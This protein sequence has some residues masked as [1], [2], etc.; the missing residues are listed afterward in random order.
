MLGPRNW[1]RWRRS[2]LGDEW[3]GDIVGARLAWSLSRLSWRL[4]GGRGLGWISAS[5]V[6]RRQKP[7]KNSSWDGLE[8][9]TSSESNHFLTVKHI[10]IAG[11]CLSW[12][13]NHLDVIVVFFGGRQ[14]ACN[15]K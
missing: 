2:S 10:N 3:N 14:S 7:V 15:L 1:R 4:C 5:A 11:H 9:D 12:S 6:N 13:S 8:L